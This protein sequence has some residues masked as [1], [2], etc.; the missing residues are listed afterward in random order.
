MITNG[1]Q[2]ILDDPGRTDAEKLAALRVLLQDGDTSQKR[3][4]LF[5]PVFAH[6]YPAAFQNFLRLVVTVAR[7]CPQ[8]RFDPWVLPRMPVHGAMN[9]AVEAAL[10]QGHDYLIAFDD[11]CL[12]ELPEFAMG[13]N[14]RWQV[15]PRM[16]ALGEMGH[17]IVTGVGYMRGY[18]HTTTIGRKYPWGMSLVIENE[19][20]Q[21]APVMKGF[22]WMDDVASHASECDANGLLDVDFCGVPILCIHRD[23]LTTVAKPLFETRDDVGGQSTHDV[24]FCNKAKAAGFAVTVDTHIDCGHIIEPPIINKFTK[25][26]MQQA[27]TPA[28]QE[29]VDA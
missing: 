1:F 13:D 25:A 28:K 9:M 6:V 11:D 20:G 22:H 8:Y 19:L 14:R 29:T 5:F 7:L 10:E 15:L 16:L 23:V 2:R 12:P 3:V 24:Y 4:L 21:E 27:L 17:K 18:P 26:G